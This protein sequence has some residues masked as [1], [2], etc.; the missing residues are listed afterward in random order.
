MSTSSASAQC[1]QKW[2]T[3]WAGSVQGPYPIGNAFLMDEAGLTI[4]VERPRM[5]G[6]DSVAG[7]HVFDF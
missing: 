7:H 1:T 6:H 4:I 2:V 5:D 3:S